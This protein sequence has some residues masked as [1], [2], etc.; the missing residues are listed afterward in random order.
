MSGAVA[1]ATLSHFGARPVSAE[2]LFG[3]E[4]PRGSD[5]YVA[6]AVEHVRAQSSDVSVTR[7]GTTVRCADGDPCDLGPCGDGLCTL[8]LR[9]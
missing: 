8:S 7:R 2:L 9:K 1:V 5:C 3:R 4:G 6:L